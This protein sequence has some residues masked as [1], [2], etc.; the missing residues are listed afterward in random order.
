MRNNGQHELTLPGVGQDEIR[1]Q[2]D[3]EYA[4]PTADSGGS[5]GTGPKGAGR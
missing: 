1:S 2:D 5:G 4:Y 3:E